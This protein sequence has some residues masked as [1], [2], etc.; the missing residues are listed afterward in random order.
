M[1]AKYRKEEGITQEELGRAAGVST[2][3]VSRWE[4]GG[5]PDVEL[6]PAIADRLHVSIDALFGRDAGEAADM[7]KLLYQRLLHAPKERCM[8]EMLQ[9]IWVMQ[10]AVFL[11]HVPELWSVFELLPIQ[12]MDRGAEEHP[13]QIPS[14]MI[15]NNE[16]A[17]MIYG[18]VK[19]RRFALVF[20]E[21]EKGWASAMK[22]TKE[23]VRL[24]TL[25]AKPHYLEMLIDMDMRE[26]GGHFTVR[27]AASRLGISEEEA[28]AIL[29]ELTEH[30]MAERLT[31]KDEEGTLKIYRRGIETNLTI[32]LLFCE[33]MMRSSKTMYMNAN[34]RQKPMF[35]EQPGTGSLMPK[36]A[37]REE[38][39]D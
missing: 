18:T 25:L 24:F 13:E 21:P 35:A 14:E 33:E 3:A 26:A 34:I 37:T 23:Y 6:L 7:E 20:P 28:E 30:M 19:D 22:G 16:E 11:N 38:E 32:F 8:E 17:C 10:Q 1:I 5:T 29:E 39:E 9:Y 4:C 31:V 27:L 12:I 2:Q 36:W 15:L